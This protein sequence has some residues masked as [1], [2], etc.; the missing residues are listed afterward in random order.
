ME[1][2]AVGPLVLLQDRGRPGLAHLGV[3]RAGALDPRAAALANRLVGN[4]ADAAVLEVIGGITLLAGDGRWV[5][6]TGAAGRVEVDGRVRSLHQAVWLPAG[7]Q[8]TVGAPTV[9]VRSYVAVAGG[10]DVAPV[11]GSRSTDTLAWIGPPPVRAGAVLPLGVAGRPALTDLVVS[12]RVP[13]SGT[14]LRLLAGPHQQWFPPGALEEMARA[15]WTVQPESNRVGLRL[16]GRTP[17]PRAEGELPSEG[18]VLGAVQVP[19]D[20]QPVVLLNDHGTVGGYPVVGVVHPDDLPACAQLRP[21]DQVSL[22]P[23][24]G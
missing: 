11:L 13:H 15:T 3:P 23:A 7:G 22:R 16:R 18:T 19:P 10:F 24:R 1:V 20:G 21:G 5:A 12:S 2:S 6:V 14:T 4:S 8:L 17:V 9:G